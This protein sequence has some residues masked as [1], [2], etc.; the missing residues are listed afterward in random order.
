MSQVT[1]VT[2][3]RPGKGPMPVKARSREI[4]I[5]LYIPRNATQREAVTAWAQVAMN[6]ADLLAKP[7]IIKPEASDNA[8]RRSG[9]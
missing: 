5:G 4:Q 1:D 6:I 2:S 9:L 8:L 7:N 3:R